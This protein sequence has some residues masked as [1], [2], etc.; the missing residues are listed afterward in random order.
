[1][2]PIIP[3]DMIQGGTSALIALYKVFG[4]LFGA[5][6]RP[7]HRPDAP[8]PP[9]VPPGTNN[10]NEHDKN[11]QNNQDG[12]QNNQDGKQGNQHSEQAVNENQEVKKKLDELID[13]LKKNTSRTGGADNPETDN[14][15]VQAMRDGMRDMRNLVGGAADANAARAAGLPMPSLAGLGSPLGGGLGG[16][17]PGMSPFGGGMFGGPGAGGAPAFNPFSDH[18]TAP[19]HQPDVTSPVDTGG[20]TDH[21]VGTA[22]HDPSAPSPDHHGGSAGGDPHAIVADPATAHTREITAPDGTKTTAPDDVAYAALNH[23]IDNPNTPNAAEAAYQA[24][25]NPI[26]GNGADPGKV[27]DINDIEPADI[28]RFTDHDS[29]VFGNGKIINPDGGL[30]PIGDAMKAATFTGIF[31]PQR[32]ST[33]GTQPTDPHPPQHTDTEP[34]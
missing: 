34:T 26:P 32:T 18:D 20:G 17:M 30:Q 5:G 1:M 4:R 11:Q 21:G 23:Y 25:N 10:P 13:L 9:Q 33:P 31:R 24:A 16:G 14:A 28:V 22:S 27:I 3:A 8:D 15:T 12:K 29:M 6:N 19:H 2:F 7:E